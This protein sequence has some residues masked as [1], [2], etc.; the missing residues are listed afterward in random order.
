MRSSAPW[1]Q[2]RW[3][4][5]LAYFILRDKKD[6]LGAVYQAFAR[7]GL[8]AQAQR[9]KEQKTRK[10]EA[11]QKISLDRLQSHVCRGFA[12]TGQSMEGCR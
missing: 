4:F 7:I 2:P 6:A 8:V 11:R 5:S 3:L 12:G 10:G 9:K 1:T